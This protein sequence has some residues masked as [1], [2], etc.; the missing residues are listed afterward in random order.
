MAVNIDAPFIHVGDSNGLPYVGAQL[1]VYQ[2]G[3]TTK[4]EIYS[5]AS[6][7]QQLANPLTSDAAGNF[8]RAYLAAGTYKLRAETSASVLIWQHDNIDTGLGFGSGALS[9]ASGGTGG[10]TAA[11]ARTSLGAASQTDVDDLT[12]EIADINSSLQSIVSAPQGYLTLISGTPV[13]ASDVSAGTAVYYTPFIGNLVPIWNGSQHIIFSFSELTLTLSSN[14]TANNIYDIFITLDSGVP[15]IVT[16]PAWNT[17]TA[18]SGARGSGAGTTQLSRF[19]GL[20]VNTVAMTARN[21]ATTY[22]V[23]ANAATYVGSL[24]MDGTNGQAS[25]HVTYGQSRKRA[26]WNAYNRQPIALRAGDSTASWN[27]TTNTVRA[28]NG[29]ANNKVTVFCGLAEEHVFVEFTQNVEAATA[30]DNRPAVGIGKNSTSATSG[31]Y[32]SMATP[33]NSKTNAIAKFYDLP[34]IGINA[35]QSLENGAPT[36]GVYNGT[37]ADMLLTAHWR[38]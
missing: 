20:W 6:L 34:F 35:Y 8:P 2:A 31:F 9:V 13:I 17:P 4:V 30:S 38:G 32:G 29:D 23:E 7:T 26:V 19:G 37:E 14:H 12:A 18:G 10:T 16:G 1:Y 15:I 36:G 3:T 33:N 11:A 5:D 25:S 22:S 21:G 28:S 24:F 27:Y